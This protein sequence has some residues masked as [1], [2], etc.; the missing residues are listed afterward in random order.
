MILARKENATTNTTTLTQI[1]ANFTRLYF[2]FRQ[3]RYVFFSNSS[4]KSK[5]AG[6]ERADHC[7]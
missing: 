6:K 1:N 2:I 7:F 3:T 5:R 4:K